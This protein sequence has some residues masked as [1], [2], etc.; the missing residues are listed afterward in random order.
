[1][2]LDFEE[3]DSDREEAIHRALDA[4]VKVIINVGASLDS[5]RKAVELAHKYKSVF[6]A[7]SVHPHDAQ[8]V[9]DSVLYE[10]D[11]LAGDPRVVA[12]GE[13]GLDFYRNLSA[14]DVQERVFSAFIEIARKH[15][16]PL[17][18]HSRDSTAE[19]IEFIAK[20]RLPAGGVFHCFSSS[21][22]NAKR[23]FS[24]GF[25]IS[26]AGNI[27]FSNAEKL[28]FKISQLPLENLMLETD[29]PY[30]APHPFRGRRCEPLYIPLIATQIAQLFNTTVEIVA[31]VTTRNALKLFRISED[32]L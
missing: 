19:A 12:I 4:G 3:F 11:S 2:H 29:C 24:L 30:L 13:T 32:L 26:V 15:N 7:V 17:I 27:T 6:A 28:R 9:D 5:S 21:V 8:N 25:L 20:N 16:K 18:V 10:I 14:R 23:L 22:E 1:S 31:E